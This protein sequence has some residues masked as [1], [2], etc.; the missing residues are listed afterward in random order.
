MKL[1][2]VSL[3]GA[4]VLLFSACTKDDAGNEGNTSVPAV[5]KAVD[6]TV[7]H[8]N[9]NHSHLPSERKS[10]YFSGVKTKTDMGGFARVASK[11]KT[12]QA[13]ETN[14]ITLSAG[15]IIQG[16][17]YYSV[18]K[19]EADAAAMNQI[20]WDALTLGNHEF[21]DGDEGLK[22]LLDQMD[23]EFVSA[24]VVPK[25]GNILEGYWKPYKIIEREGEK[26]ALLG[27]DIKQK[28]QVSSRPSDEIEFFDEVETSQKYADELKAKGV[29]KIILISHFGMKNDLDL[30][31]KVD[32]IDVIVDGD[33][34]SLLG[35]FSMV[36]LQSS[37]DTYPQRTTSKSGEKV[38][39]VSA[40]QYNYMVGK[41]HVS[42]DKDGKV[43]SC[44]GVPYLLLDDA[45]ITVNKVEMNATF[46]AE[47]EAIFSDN[48][49]I[50]SVR[51]DDAVVASLK[52][53]TEKIEAQKDEVVGTAKEFLGHNR[54]P[55]HEYNG[56]NL[57]LGSD[58]APLVAYSF[59]KASRRA[60][61][62]IQN[63]GGVRIS[64]D[65]GNITIGEAYTLLP[66]SNTLFE[67]DMTGSEIKQ[68]LEDALNNYL[69]NGG[70][71]GSFPYA[72]GL[73][74]DV[75]VNA[76]ANSRISNLQIMERATSTFAPIEA[77]KTYVIVTNDYIA[78]GRDGYTTFKTVQDERGE[79]VNTYLDYADSF[80]NLVRELSKENRELEKLPSNEH[81]I[82]SYKEQ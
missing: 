12:L 5:H 3:I 71:T 41:L 82:N 72:F 16:T 73:K 17:L 11:I 14:P 78:G 40:W 64:I 32:G 63:A 6:V 42:F 80:V 51:E 19:G 20:N 70:S 21:D 30:A 81:P 33:S 44:E 35:D 57:P 39:V 67:I 59:Y 74:Y 47:V 28:T 43:T 56:I 49:Q 77:S 53:F 36:G 76:S 24:N 34:H 27:I 8:V 15:D 54:I 13:S 26:I 75:D 37:Y 45:N 4:V 65:E 68:V 9:D 25:K 55:T 50:D 69:D 46:K 2:T 1:Q 29:N 58:I 61:A 66:F 52:P 38:C 18:Y 62:C 60:D 22:T 23:G 31:T 10:V 48:E 79:G 7:I